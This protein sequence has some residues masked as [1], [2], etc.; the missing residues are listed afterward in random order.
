MM[1]L[2]FLNTDNKAVIMLLKYFKKNSI[3]IVIITN[4]MQIIAITMHYNEIG[5]L[6]MWSHGH[7]S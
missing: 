6:L 3:I 1:R 7:Q 4:Y 5:F 2:S